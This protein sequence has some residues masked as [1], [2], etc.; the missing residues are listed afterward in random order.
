[1]GSVFGYAS[2]IPVRVVNRENHRRVASGTED[3]EAARSSN[4]AQSERS[5]PWK[6]IGLSDWRERIMFVPTAMVSGAGPWAPELQAAARIPHPLHQNVRDQF[7]EACP[8]N[9]L[10]AMMVGTL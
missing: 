6:R 4:R 8:M 5:S 7:H 2:S 10:S 1:M 3:K 9:R